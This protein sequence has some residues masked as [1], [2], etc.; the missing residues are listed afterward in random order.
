MDSSDLLLLQQSYTNRI[1]QGQRYLGRLGLFGHFTASQ[2]LTALNRYLADGELPAANEGMLKHVI[3]ALEYQKEP[4]LA[5]VPESILAD[6]G[7]TRESW[8]MGQGF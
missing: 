5:G 3:D 6:E 7:G 8:A 1:E 2:K 4:L